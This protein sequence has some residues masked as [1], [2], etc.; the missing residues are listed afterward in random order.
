ML[1]SKQVGN[2]EFKWALYP[3]SFQ[4]LQMSAILS[5]PPPPKDCGRPLWTASYQSHFSLSKISQIFLIIFFI[6]V[7]TIITDVF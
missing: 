5:P 1:T 4:K 2:F 3:G 7:L 6:E